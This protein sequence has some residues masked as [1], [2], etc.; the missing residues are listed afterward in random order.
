MRLPAAS[1]RP[2]IN[3]NP[4]LMG[5]LIICRR[6]QLMIPTAVIHID[7]EDHNVVSSCVLYQ[8]RRRIKAHGLTVEQSNIKGGGVMHFSQAET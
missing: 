6:H 8:L 3:R 4:S 1:L 2:F 5:L 7:G